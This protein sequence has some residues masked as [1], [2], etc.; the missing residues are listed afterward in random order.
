M[1]MVVKGSNK[2]S[3]NQQVVSMRLLNPRTD[4]YTLVRGNISGQ[5]PITLSLGQAFLASKLKDVVS[6]KTSF[7]AK[8]TISGNIFDSYQPP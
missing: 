2:N 6:L 5:Q 4:C 3:T 1:S 8:E 7:I